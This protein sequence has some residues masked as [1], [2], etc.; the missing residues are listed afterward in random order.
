MVDLEEVI[1]IELCDILKDSLVFNVPLLQ[2][3]LDTLWVIIALVD[4]DK[5]FFY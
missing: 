4:I 3:N 1:K 5:T 2:L